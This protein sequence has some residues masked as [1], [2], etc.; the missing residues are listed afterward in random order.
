[1]ARP[2]DREYTLHR[3]IKEL[4][5][6]NDKLK[7][8]IAQLEKRLEREEPKVMKKIQKQGDCP[9]CQS[10]TKTTVLPFGKLKI[11]SAACG[12]REVTRD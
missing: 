4:E 12:F 6:Q 7:K 3:K 2:S 9:V 10:P 1:M 8:Q 5:E 11:C